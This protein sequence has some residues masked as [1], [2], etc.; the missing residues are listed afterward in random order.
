MEAVQTWG[1]LYFCHSSQKRRKPPQSRQEVA[2]GGKQDVFR[3]HHLQ[4]HFLFNVWTLGGY[5]SCAGPP[6]VSDEVSRSALS[7]QNHGCFFL[8]LSKFSSNSG[9]NSFF[10]SFLLGVNG[11]IWWRS[12]HAASCLCGGRTNIVFVWRWGHFTAYHIFSRVLISVTVGGKQANT[13]RRE[14]PVS[15]SSRIHSDV[16]QRLP[17]ELSLTA[18]WEVQQPHLIQKVQTTRTI[19][20]SIWKIYIVKKRVSFS[21]QILQN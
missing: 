19:G 7:H 6:R 16:P 2:G 18:W 4:F 14:Q 10:W 11:V 1:D 9:L 17:Y 8:P 12:L 21:R 13:E 5:W 3:W 15:T 20:F